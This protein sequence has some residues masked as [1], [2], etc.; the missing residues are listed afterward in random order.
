MAAAG[1]RREMDVIKLMR[2]NY[3]VEMVE[4]GSLSSFGG[5]GNNNA[6]RVGFR[7]KFHGPSESNYEGGVW[8]VNV[9]LPTDYP[10]RS[11]SIG[12]SNHIYHPNIDFRSGSVCLDVIN[13]TWSPMFDLINIFDV[14]LPQL[15]K[16]PN[17]SDPLNGE[18]AA[19]LMKDEK[20]FQTKVKDLIK[21][22]AA[23]TEKDNAF[24]VRIKSRKPVS[25]VVS[26]S[27]SSTPSF[28]L[29]LANNLG[30]VNGD[31]SSTNVG[32]YGGI[33]SSGGIM[34]TISSSLP[35]Q[36]SM[37]G[38]FLHS[39]TTSSAC[40]SSTSGSSP[41]KTPSSTDRMDEE[42]LSSLSDQEEDLAADMEL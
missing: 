28:S 29:P 2:S 14:F 30:N 9:D 27:L 17:P 13:Q 32:S 6:G 40:S 24:G 26:S 16:Y 21:L 8:Y 23:P 4:E 35:Y 34:M 31:S 1:K 7:V 20:R 37:A 41:R 33:N 39:G 36:Q 12:F 38:S 3:A 11:P 18:A 10:Y 25:N 19:L 15:L 22:Y 5:N 42:D